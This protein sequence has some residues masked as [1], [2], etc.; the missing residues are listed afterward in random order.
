MKGIRII[1]GEFRGRRLE[2][3]DLPGLRPTTDRLRETIFNVIAHRTD[4]E[5]I[6]VLDMFAGSGALGIEALSRGAGHADFVEVGGAGVELIGRNLVHVGAAER[7][8][9]HRGD[10]FQVAGRLGRYDL[11]LADPPYT[12]QKFPELM[13][14]AP[15]LLEPGGL[16]M[17]ER[18]NPS[19]DLPH[20]G[21][22]PVDDRT[23]GKTRISLYRVP[24]INPV[25]ETLSNV[26]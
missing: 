21:L 17:L 11:I 25:T 16:F 5:G 22:E 18:G 13:L 1:A 24:Y 9:L 7:A 20:E 8:T 23:A 15:T 12:L 10:A 6:R 2:V 3:G 26:D 4:F 14:L 19:K